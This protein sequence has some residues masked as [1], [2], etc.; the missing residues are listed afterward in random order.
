[1]IKEHL[2]ESK[3]GGKGGFRIKEPA[4]RKS[5]A[6]LIKMFQGKIEL[7]DCMFR[8]KICG[9]RKD[10]VLRKNIKRIED[11][12]EKE[13]KSITIAGLLNDMAKRRC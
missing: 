3:E 2:V 10:C 1:M 13:F 7:S 5:A 4:K 11:I 6:D 8:R 9:N 12:V